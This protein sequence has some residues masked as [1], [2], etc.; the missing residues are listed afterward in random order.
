M[1]HGDA[2]PN[3]SQ[4]FQEYLCILDTRFHCY[5]LARLAQSP[6]HTLFNDTSQ[7][8]LLFSL[9]VLR[10]PWR[11]TQDTPLGQSALNELHSKLQAHPRSAQLTLLMS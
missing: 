2:A 5:N 6:T 8:L 1:Y 4:T 7:L 3:D 11:E 10:K 9:V